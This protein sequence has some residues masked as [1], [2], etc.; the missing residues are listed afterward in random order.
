MA[1]DSVA[2]DGPATWQTCPPTPRW[3]RVHET[4]TED[5]DLCAEI[6]KVLVEGLQ[7]CASRA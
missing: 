6:M 2:R 3:Y 4:F 7:G 5:A 1:R